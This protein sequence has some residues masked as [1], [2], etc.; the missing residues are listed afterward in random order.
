[1]LAKELSYF[2]WWPEDFAWPDI[3]FD[4]PPSSV[5]PLGEAG[6]EF[7]AGL[8]DTIDPQTG[9][10]QY[11]M[12]VPVGIHNLGRLNQTEFYRQIAQSGVLVGVG[13]PVTSPSPYEALC[14]GVPFINPVMGWDRDDP[15]NRT[16]WNPQHPGLK[17]V[18]EPY[19]YH[20]KKGDAV[21]F[22]KAVKRAVETPIERCV[23]GVSL[24]KSFDVDFLPS[25][26]AGILF[27]R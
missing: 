10:N 11:N 5:F 21:E 8:R 19:V 18:E 22:W 17:F 14:L 27:R 15:E 13:K 4:Q 6:I 20:V 7:Y 16:K 1:M 9:L 3:T 23:L 26:W 12:S 24:D 25:W 2:G